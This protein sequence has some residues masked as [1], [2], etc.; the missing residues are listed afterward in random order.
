L[1]VEE[2]QLKYTGYF[3]GSVS[4]TRESHVT[5]YKANT[6]VDANHPA[7]TLDMNIY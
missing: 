3:A 5:D 4:P 1:C 6:V 7:D 2:W